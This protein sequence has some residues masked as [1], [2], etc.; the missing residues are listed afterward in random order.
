VGLWRFMPRGTI[1][2][3]THAYCCKRCRHGISA[4]IDFDE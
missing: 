2:A 4:D 3:Y 1:A